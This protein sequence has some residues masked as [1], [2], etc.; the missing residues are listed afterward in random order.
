M[1]FLTLVALLVMLWVPVD[2]VAQGRNPR[3]PLTSVSTIDDIV[4]VD[5][6][7]DI[8]GKSEAQYTQELENA[9]ELGL[10]RT[11]IPLTPGFGPKLMCSVNLL[12][13]S[14]TPQVVYSVSLYYREIMVDWGAAR[15][16]QDSGDLIDIVEDA[17]MAT[18]WA[19]GSVGIMGL[20]V[21][22]GRSTGE[23]CAEAFELEWRRANN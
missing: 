3:N 7:D 2:G 10:L 20:S 8:E 12:E 19:R 16:S 13:N 9:F 22:S 18:T 23:W 14:N 5:W 4:V 1:R 17:Q 15:R 6:D 21:L 11:G